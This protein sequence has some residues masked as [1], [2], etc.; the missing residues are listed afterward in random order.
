MYFN[1]INFSCDLE[2]EIED[3]R[4]TFTNK[5]EEITK[6][7]TTLNKLNEQK[8]DME[9]KLVEHGHTESEKKILNQRTNDLTLE[10]EEIERNINPLRRNIQKLESDKGI[11]TE[12]KKEQSRK[13]EKQVK[14]SHFNVYCDHP[15]RHGNK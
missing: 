13:D 9:R 12:K 6:L 5:T 10:S 1:G 8:F 3:N 4:H 7:K 11:V 14:T 15:P 2:R